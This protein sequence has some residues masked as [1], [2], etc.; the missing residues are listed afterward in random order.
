MSHNQEILLECKC[1]NIL[2]EDLL[3]KSADSGEKP[4]EQEFVVLTEVQ[5]I[6]STHWLAVEA[7]SWK[8]ISLNSRHV[9]AVHAPT[10]EDSGVPAPLSTEHPSLSNTLPWIPTKRGRAGDKWTP[11]SLCKLLCLFLEH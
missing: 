9:T 8:L 4:M 1:D 6:N 5:P 10:Q 7:S 11:V 3:D 2:G